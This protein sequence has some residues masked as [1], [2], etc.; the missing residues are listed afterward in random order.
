MDIGVALHWMR[1][2]HEGIPWSAFEDMPVEE[3]VARFRTQKRMAREPDEMT[4]WTL[5][6]L[7]HFLP[8]AVAFWRPIVT[9][10]K[11]RPAE[12]QEVDVESA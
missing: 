4:R 10:S 11:K 6:I 5:Q 1:F 2:Q 12:S 8:I 7:A 9:L 3:F